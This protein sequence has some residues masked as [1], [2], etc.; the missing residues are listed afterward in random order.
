MTKIG[1]II[2]R[3]WAIASRAGAAIASEFDDGNAD[4]ETD[5]SALPSPSL[6]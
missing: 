2:P 4:S 6:P 1:P 5:A 3:A